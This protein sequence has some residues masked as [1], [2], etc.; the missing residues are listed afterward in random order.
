MHEHVNRVPPS[1]G[2]VS[3]THMTASTALPHPAYL[4]HI[5]TE[6]ARFREVL[7]GCD[8]EARVPACPDWDAADL[9]WHLADVQ[10]SW[11][12][13]IRTRPA[14]PD[15]VDVPEPQ[16]PESYAEL[17]EAFDSFSHAL[18]TELE[19]ADPDEPAWH[20]GP[21]QTVGATYRRQAHEAL[22][23]RLDAEETAGSVTPLDPALSADGVDEALTLMYGGGP[24]WGV[25][26]PSE[27]VV[28]VRLS[29][30]GHEF[31]VALA[32]FTGTDPDDGKVYDEPDIAVVAADWAR[33]AATVTGTAADLDT[34]LWHRG[35]DR[36][37]RAGTD[38]GARV[39]VEGDRDVFERLG[40]I[41][42]QPLN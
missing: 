37:V 11:A 14:A 13:T 7:A 33:P 19:R 5:R 35:A 41:L 38:P 1:T 20:W 34:W 9:L 27:E 4:D 25:I 22:I 30:T 12:R 39:L 36:E 29:D 18:A 10:W 2:L 26:T 16:R 28:L 15:E 21:V 32:R 17:L 40:A 6:S 23:H 3:V 31:P 8:P 42:S 24:P